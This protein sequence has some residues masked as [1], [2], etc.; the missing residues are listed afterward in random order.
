[1]SENANIPPRIDVMRIGILL[2]DLGNINVAAL[3]F[4]ILQMNMLQR[5]FEYE[6]LLIPH[7]DQFINQFIQKLSYGNPVDR[8]DTK[9]A[10]P[11]LVTHYQ[12]ILNSQSKQFAVKE[13]PVD[14]FILVTMACFTDGF[15]TAYGDQLTVLSLGRWEDT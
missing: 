7:K 8:H 11:A 12:A 10:V 2:G 1:M 3:K 15:Y 13:L 9:K 5:T 4:L 6:F 14:H